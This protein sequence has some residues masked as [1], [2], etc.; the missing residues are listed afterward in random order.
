MSMQDDIDVMK[1]MVEDGDFDIALEQFAIHVLKKAQEEGVKL[2]EKIKV[3][4]ALQ[5]YHA[6]REKYKGKPG[7]SGPGKNGPAGS[8]GFSFGK[9]QATQPENNQ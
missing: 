2:E 8:Q 3:F 6:A 1:S 9:R 7:G 4:E 5:P